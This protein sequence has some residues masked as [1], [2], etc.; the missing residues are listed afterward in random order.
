MTSNS[1]KDTQP[2]DK[3]LVVGTDSEPKEIIS[4]VW[5]WFLALL[6]SFLVGFAI[7]LAVVWPGMRDIWSQVSLQFGATILL[8]TVLFYIERRFLR[9]VIRQTGEELLR[10]LRPNEAVPDTMRNPAALQAATEWF[11]SVVNGEFNRAWELSEENWRL[12]RAQAWIWNNRGVLGLAD[13]AEMEELAKALSKVYSDHP[14]WIR[15][16]QSERDQLFEAVAGARNKSWGAATGRRCVGPGYELFLFFELRDD[17]R[18]GLEVR[19]PT[20]VPGTYPCLMH[21]TSEG[22]RLAAYSVEA[23]P[24]PGFPPAWWIKYDPVAEEATDAMTAVRG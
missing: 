19:G 5:L 1:S 12:C 23:P 24:Q 11:S 7:Y 6:G 14:L 18:Y 9:R 16:I 15:F 2:I 22:W 13:E 4:Y 21:L 10:A 8:F 20:L 17:Y 3:P